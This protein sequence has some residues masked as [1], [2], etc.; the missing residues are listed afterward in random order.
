[1]PAPAGRW[2]H[3]RPGRPFARPYR[4]IDAFD[5]VFN[6]SKSKCVICRHRGAV[7]NNTDRSVE[8]M[9]FEICGNAIEVVTS[10]PHLDLA[11]I[12]TT[13]NT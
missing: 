3:G 1:M 9:S 13:K 11:M 5:V 7:R 10:W 8:K 4:N 2:G 6:A 12:V